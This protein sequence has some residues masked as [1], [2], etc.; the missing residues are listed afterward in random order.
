MTIQNQKELIAAKAKIKE[1]WD[2]ETRTIAEAMSLIAEIQH[3]TD[4]VIQKMH[5][6]RAPLEL[7]AFGGPREEIMKKTGRDPL[8]GKTF[9]ELLTE[10]FKG[11]PE[12]PF[13]D[14]AIPPEY[15]DLDK[16]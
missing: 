13:N 2:N 15:F 9:G 6:D 7:E 3:A 16:L 12:T 1:S 11:M 8:T 14:P 10:A 4:Q 5:D